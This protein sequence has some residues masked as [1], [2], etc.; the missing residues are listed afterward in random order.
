MMI[1]YSVCKSQLIIKT[2]ENRELEKRKQGIKKKKSNQQF[3]PLI[4][5]TT[6]LLSLREHRW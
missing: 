5:T 4:P 6:A 1:L 3:L 2:L